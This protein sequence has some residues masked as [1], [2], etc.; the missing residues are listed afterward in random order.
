M[1]LQEHRSGLFM[2]ADRMSGKKR[3]AKG[4]KVMTQGNAEIKVAAMAF[5]RCRL[6]DNG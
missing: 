4:T 3:N 1:I 2:D 6:P 5:R